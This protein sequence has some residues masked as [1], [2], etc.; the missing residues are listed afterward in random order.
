MR[1]AGPAAHPA[2]TDQ[3]LELRDQGLTWNEGAEQADMTV[4]GA[5]RRYRRARP[6]NHQSL[7]LAGGADIAVVS[8]LLG[9]ASIAIT[10]D[11]YAS[12]V[13]DI[14]QQAVNGAANL[15][16]SRSLAQR[17]AQA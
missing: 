5:W 16:A 8:K 6:P 17:G 7:M 3:I 1:S 11:V 2:S 13:G 12:L 14:D 15:I 9:H 4:S 10:A